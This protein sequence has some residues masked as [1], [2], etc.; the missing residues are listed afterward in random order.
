MPG[1]RE[2]YA[3]FG[4]ALAAGD[5]DGD[6]YADL[7]V[8]V[9]NATVDGVKYAGAA[10]VLHGRAGGITADGSQLWSQDSP[11]VADTAENEVDTEG[12]LLGGDLFGSALAIGDFDRDGYGDLAV[13][14]PHEQ[15]SARDDGAVNVL[16]G[17][18]EGADRQPVTNSGTR[19]CPASPAQRRRATGSAKPWPPGTSTATGRT[20]SR[21]VSPARRSGSAPLAGAVVTLYGTTNGLSVVRSQ[22]WSQNRA[23]VPGVAE[24]WDRFGASLAIANYG[25][26][27][28]GDLAIGVPGQ[29]LGSLTGAGYVNVIYG[30]STGLSGTGAQGWSQNTSGVLGTAERSDSL[31]STLTP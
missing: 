13:G 21:S 29:G 23:G 15:V 3:L 10:V 6:G 1:E 16:Y 8:G 26:S 11:G 17:S 24:R 5:L 22:S 30:R 12:G 31:G 9:P 27:S 19:T 14:V 28:R 25:R 2:V 18:A 7:A 4:E 20:T